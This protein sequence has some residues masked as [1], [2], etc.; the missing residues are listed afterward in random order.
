M[1]WIDLFFPDLLLSGDIMRLRD[2]LVPEHAHSSV[3]K[4]ISFFFLKKKKTKE[5]IFR[6]SDEQIMTGSG[7]HVVD[8]FICEPIPYRTAIRDNCTHIGST[9]T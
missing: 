3:S 4:R 8:A 7:S 5:E 6:S 1:R 9:R 2:E